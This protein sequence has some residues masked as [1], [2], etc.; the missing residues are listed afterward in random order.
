MNKR[1]IGSWYEQLA[2]RYIKENG[3][4]ILNRNYRLKNGEIDIIAKDDNYL[5]FIE[6]KYRKDQKYGG[7]EAAVSFHKQ[8]QICHVSRYYVYSKGYSEFTPIRYDVIA[9]SGEDGNSSI[10]WIKNAFDYIS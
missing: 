1:N 3:A 6:V 9:V 8:K 4:S 10:K 7:P 2:C 5:C